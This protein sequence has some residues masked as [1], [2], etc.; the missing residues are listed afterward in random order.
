MKVRCPGH[1]AK[2]FQDE[3]RPAGR[4]QGLEITREV[5]RQIDGE[6][7][8]IEHHWREFKKRNEG[9]ARCLL[10]AAQFFVARAHGFASWPK[11]AQHLGAL[12]RANSPVALDPRPL[13]VNSPRRSCSGNQDDRGSRRG[14][15]LI[16]RTQRHRA[17]L[18]ND[19]VGDR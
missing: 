7:E 11:F 13:T 15:V 4:L 5:R 12:A 18:L 10:S 2:E 19:V 9:A 17:V 3:T 14:S 1:V 8:R 6:V 16:S